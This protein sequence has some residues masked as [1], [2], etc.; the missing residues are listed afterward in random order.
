MKHSLIALVAT[1]LI[2]AAA[3]VAVAGLPSDPPG[4]GLRI[5]ELPATTST[6]AVASPETSTTTTL[7]AADSDS[8]TVLTTEAAEPAEPS[9]PA[10]DS[11]NEAAVTTT[12]TTVSAEPT[13]AVLLVRDQLVVV[14]VNAGAR[15]GIAG[16]T[17]DVLRPIGY[18]S[19][20]PFDAIES[21]ETSNVHYREGLEA[22]AVRLAEDLGWSKGDIAPASEA[23]AYETALPVDLAVVL[24][25][26]SG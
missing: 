20:V 10:S 12:I 23:P 17:A 6:S 7:A 2:A 3:G 18:P 9:I 13:E 15:A 16:E 24:G 22:E 26:D 14:T 4:I 19:A 5:T 1:G 8:S 11:V 25:R 21:S